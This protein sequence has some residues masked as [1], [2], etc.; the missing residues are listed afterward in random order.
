MRCPH[1]QM[2]L[3][4]I[5]LTLSFNLSLNKT[6][7]LGEINTKEMNYYFTRKWKITTLYFEN[8]EN[9]LIIDNYSSGKF[10]LLT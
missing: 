3:W 6:I 1:Y 5:R 7:F 4:K 10:W 2:F 8:F 9:K